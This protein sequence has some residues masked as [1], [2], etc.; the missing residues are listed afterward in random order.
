MKEFLKFL[1]NTPTAY[2]AA[3]SVKDILIADGF[4]ELLECEAWHLKKGGKYFVGRNMSSVLA[5]IVPTEE[6]QT[7]NITAAHLDSPTFKLKPNY[8]ITR[9]RYL[10]IN[11]EVYGGPIYNTWMDRP[12]G[13][14]GRVI[15]GDDN[16]VVAKLI[17][18]KKPLVVIPN[19]PIHYNRNVNKGVE[20]NPQIDM[21][22]IF[23]DKCFGDA[24]LKTIIANELNVEEES[25]LGSDLYLTVLERGCLVG[26]NLEFVMAPQID[27]LECSYACVKALTQANNKMSV[28]VA[29]LFDNEEIGSSTMQGAAGTLL[30]D[31]LER[32]SIALGKSKE[33]YLQ[34]LASSFIISCDNAQGFHPNYPAKYDET[35][36]CYLNGGIVIKNASR[37]SYSTDAMS[38]GYF[39]MLCKKANVKYQLNTNRSDNPGGSTL[40]VISIRQVSIPSVDIGLAQLA[41]HSAFE[42]AGSKDL[43][44]LIKALKEFYCNHLSPSK[45]EVFNF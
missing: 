45:E 19:L 6:A 41:M 14:A 11:T 10:K 39:Q 38:S 4:V 28:N 34:M 12:L 2:H 22:P 36:P 30:S 26:P 25:I 9:G 35:N 33:S 44:Y 27:N 3:R 15:I 18:I 21:L 37:G 40:G 20:L 13:I 43:E 24:S 7:F 23:A 8:E 32:I 29:V 5:F 16:K 42:T 17:N 1:E 31:T